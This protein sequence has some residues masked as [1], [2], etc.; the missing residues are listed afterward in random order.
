MA[1]R[2]FSGLLLFCLFSLS[3]R[4]ENIQINPSHPDHYTVSSGD[5][6]W[7]ISGKFLNYPGQWPLLWRHNPQIKNPNL[8]Y[9]GDTIHFAIVG[10]KPQLSVTRAGE[11]S[12]HAPSTATPPPAYQAPEPPAPPP[13]LAINEGSGCVLKLDDVK[14]GRTEFKYDD[15][16]KLLPCVRET[17]LEQAIPLIPLDKI[18]QFL[19][20]PRVVGAGE[21]AQAPYVVEMAGEHLITGAGDRVYVRSIPEGANSVHTIY[22]SGDIY[23]DAETGEILGYEAKFI[24]EAMLQQAGDPATMAISKSTSDIRIGDRVM[25]N[26]VDQDV[27]LNFFPRPPNKPIRGNIISVLNGVSQVGLF[28]VVVIDKG[29][30]D[31]LMVGHE[32]AVFRKGRTVQDKNSA[33]Q[34][35]MVKLPDEL[36]GS[37]MIFRTFDR[38]SY[39]LVMKATQAIHVLDRVQTP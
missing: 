19:T 30:R 27:T 15:D 35:D 38:I 2:T 24:A 5:T 26:D 22:R 21:L 39:A 37:M 16:G 7:D 6:L 4:A 18:R 17:P 31:G 36:A 3:V 10:G 29:L 1:F 32:L 20:S 12:Y 28:N 34:G 23:T 11:S 8:I 13:E 9:P 14:N 25:T 33:I